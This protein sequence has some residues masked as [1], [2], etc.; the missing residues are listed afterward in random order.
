[1]NNA[2]IRTLEVLQ[3]FCTDE[4]YK[5]IDAEDILS[6]LEGMDASSLFET[7]DNLNTERLVAVKYSDKTEY[8]LS[9]TKTGIIKVEEERARRAKEE[10]IRRERERQERLRQEQLERERLERERLEAESKSKKSPLKA[11][12]KKEPEP[13]AKS[14]IELPAE[15]VNEDGLLATYESAEYGQSLINNDIAAK[16]AQPSTLVLREV[17]LNRETMRIIARVAFFSGLI[18]AAIGSLV[19][20]LIFMFL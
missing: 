12:R 15:I 5:I 3:E 6:R 7:I 2:G 16:E 1:M 17:M 4:G 9:L 8:C 10:Q 18:G 20:S 13:A 14:N 19:I 11:F